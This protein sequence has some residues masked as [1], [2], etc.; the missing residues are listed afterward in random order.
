MVGKLPPRSP[1]AIKPPLPHPCPR[2]GDH[3]IS[4]RHLAGKPAT[5]LP[6]YS[7]SDLQEATDNFA[8]ERLLGEGRQALVY[9]ASLKGVPLAVRKMRQEVDEGDFVRE[10]MMVGRL[11][12]PRIV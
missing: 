9:R 10:A 1:M 4:L 12:H 11:Q 7:A 2:Q 3:S 5:V 6:K 8:Q